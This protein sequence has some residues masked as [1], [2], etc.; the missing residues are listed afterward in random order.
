LQKNSY[1]CRR[2]AFRV[3]VTDSGI[4]HQIAA[5][6]A[7]CS[8]ERVRFAAH[9]LALYSVTVVGQHGTAKFCWN[10]ITLIAEYLVHILWNY[11]NC[12]LSCPY[13]ICQ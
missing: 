12:R 4:I 10:W 7:L 1:R 8:E 13:I 11:F 6:T 5:V 3:D 2:T 9:A